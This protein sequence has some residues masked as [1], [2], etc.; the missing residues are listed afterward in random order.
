MPYRIS[1]TWFHRLLALSL[2]V[3]LTACGGGSSTPNSAVTAPLPA[4]HTSSKEGS[5]APPTPSLY[6]YVTNYDTNN[7]SVF[8]VNIATGTLT[9]MSDSPTGTGPGSAVVDATGTHIYVPNFDSN[10]ISVYA[11]DARNGALKQIGTPVIAGIWPAAFGITP[12]GR[13]AYVANFISNS[14]SI[15]RIDATTGALSNVGTVPA[16]TN[17]RYLV[18]DPT[19][20]FVYTANWGSKDI[21]I[22]AVNATT[23][24]LTQVGSPLAV[25]GTPFNLTSDRAGSHLYLTD[26][27]NISGA[28]GVSVLHIDQ[29][30]GALTA[31]GLNAATG[32]HPVSMTLD[33]SGRFAYVANNLNGAGGNSVS[34]FTVDTNSGAITPIDCVCGQSGYAAGT[35]PSSV[36]ASPTGTHLYV[37]NVTSNDITVYSIHSSSGAL[38]RVG[39]TTAG[40]YPM[41]IAFTP[42]PM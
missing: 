19:G 17:P 39:T 4:L 33:T 29:S 6:A 9:W 10:D 31:V 8:K 16:G 34:A 35:N 37:S 38:T 5:N 11:I 15:F 26:F 2:P 25:K 21:T 36:T 23:G 41:G 14:V 24:I 22:F 30:T 3:I 7:V 27:L 1:S 18:I 32:P 42:V 12:S 28:T 20:R 13:F 40:A